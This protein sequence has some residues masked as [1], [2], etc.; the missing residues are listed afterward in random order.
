MT[1]KPRPPPGFTSDPQATPS[2]PTG[3]LST[4]DSSTP[5]KSSSSSS[6]SS[7]SDPPPPFP[8]DL[9]AP[10]PSE[11]AALD[12]WLR[13]HESYITG[14]RWHRYAQLPAL[15]PL[16]GYADADF[17]AEC[18]ESLLFYT[19]AAGRKLSRHERDA[20]LTP[21]ARTAVAASYDR[22]LA[23][24]LAGWGMARSWAKSGMQD[25]VRKSA[26]E[27]AAAAAT[28]AGAG[29]G[30][31]GGG[32]PVGRV[33]ADGHI[34]HFAQQHQHQHQHQHQPQH[35]YG[36]GAAAAGRSAVVGSVLRRVARTSMVGLSCAAGYYALWTPYRLLLGNHEVDSIREDPRL[37][38]MCRDMDRNMKDKMA[39]IIRKHGGM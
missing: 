35:G 4:P 11:A 27:A 15:A 10:T 12:A 22:P 23:L 13:R 33:G 1:P 19:R 24:V 14:I 25:M 9:D 26:A 39:D 37:E 5:T 21:I 31:G 7:S 34:T 18:L 6:S 36:A 16:W 20:V 29:G 8:A 3:P 38:K 30:G 2:P 17:R 32:G 28:A